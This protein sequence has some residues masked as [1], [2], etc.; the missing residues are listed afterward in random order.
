MVNACCRIHFGFCLALWSATITLAFENDYGIVENVF[1]GQFYSPSFAF[2][3]TMRRLADKV[4]SEGYDLELPCKATGMQPISY[5][6]FVNEKKFKRKFR[7][8]VKDTGALLKIQ[9]LRARDSAVYTC[10]A[11]NRYGNL[12]FSYSLKIRERPGV[13]PRFYDL[14]IMKR[15]QFAVKLSG[16][17]ARFRCE[18]KSALP[19][20]YTWLK[21]GEILKKQRGRIDYSNFFL[22]IKKL[23]LSDAGNYTCVANNTFGSI[24][25]SFSLNMLRTRKGGPPKVTTYKNENYIKAKVGED[26]SLECLEST[27]TTLPFVSW[28]KWSS[29]VEKR[30]A[31]NS[32]F[33]GKRKAR[34]RVK[35]EYYHISPKYYKTFTVKG[36]SP[37]RKSRWVFD[38]TRPYGLRLNIPNVT[39]AD[40][41]MYTCVASNFE[42]SDLA[43]LLL[44][45]YT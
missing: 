35:K 45:V 43:K 24:A 11:S 5:R 39:L 30:Y 21:N 26:V 4:H 25:F 8:N 31:L 2:P 42:G 14:N 15:H 16:E 6:W 10:I 36:Y 13:A 3:K 41:G 28:F 37:F 12:S 44:Q 1:L 9:R 18:A 19:V 17:A 38:N 29:P 27:S 33:M 20:T 32:I 34:K 22:K 40:S 7:I 23:Q